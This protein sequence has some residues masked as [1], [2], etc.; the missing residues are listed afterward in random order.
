[1]P[2]QACMDTLNLGELY[3]HLSSSCQN[4]EHDI[5]TAKRARPSYLRSS[6][7][8]MSWSQGFASGDCTRDAQAIRTF[9]KDGHQLGCS[10]SYAKNMGLYGQRTG[11]FS[12]ITASAQETTSVESQ[13][14]ARPRSPPCV[15]PALSQHV[16]SFVELSRY[17]WNIHPLAFVRP[18]STIGSLEPASRGG[19]HASDGKYCNDCCD[20]AL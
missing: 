7:V 20:V 4:L 16:I 18:K 3:C 6:T 15:L 17:A 12:L 19:M 14:K 5:R 8:L 1:M 13:M 2:P 10:Q 11:C 9:L